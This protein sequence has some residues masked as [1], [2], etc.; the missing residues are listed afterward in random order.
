MKI[1][2]SKEDR[3]GFL[4]ALKE[5]YYERVE[6]A[7][8]E[9]IKK[10]PIFNLRDEG[11][12]KLIINREFVEKYNLE[13]WLENYKKEAMHSTGGI[14]GPQNVLYPWDSRFPL[15]QI[16]V[17]LATLG[18][19]LVLKDRI[20][21]REI[22]KLV[23]GEVRYN[24]KQYI[25]LISRIH[26]AQGIYTH[27]TSDNQVV[28]I[29]LTSFLIFMMDYDG[30]EFVTS[31]HAIS[32]KTATKDLDNQG[33]QFLPEMSMA[34]IDKIEGIIKVAKE[35]PEGYII[36][37]SPKTN[38]F[39]VQDVDGIEAYANYLRQGIASEENLS[40]IKNATS[41]GM[42]LMFETVGGCMYRTMVPLLKYF[43]IF[44]AFEWN[45]QLE[46]PFFH[47]VGKTKKANPKTGKEE[48]FDLSCDASLPEVQET[49]SY[50]YFLKE[51]PIGYVFLITDPDGDRL[52]MGQIEEASN[53]ENLRS[54][55]VYCIPI[56]EKRI[57]SFYH[58]TFSFLMVM[59]FYAK[60]LKNSGRWSDH[61]RFMIVTTPC[62]RAWN[63][64]GRAQGVK[65]LTTPVG[66]KEIATIIKKA[67]KKLFSEPDK[68]VIV[69]DIWTKGI[70]LGVDPR[71]IFTGEESGGMIIGPENI[72]QSRGGRKAI[73]MREKS[74]GEAS[75][76]ASALAAHLFLKKQTMADYLEEIF[77]ECRIVYRYYER[78]DITYYNESE[79][80]PVKLLAEKA[81]GE[82]KRDKIDLYYL[83]VVLALKEGLIAVGDAKEI[84]REAM[85]ELDFSSLEDVR[86]TGDA[87]YL[88]FENMFVQIRKSGTDAKLRGYSNGDNREKC[89]RYMDILVHYSGEITTSYDQKIPADFR[90][91]IYDKTKKI[92][93]DYL[94][95]GL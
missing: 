64:W 61:P 54:L 1:F 72:V 10:N 9:W 92:Y 65:I 43:G 35:S 2:K 48:F 76:I 52:T 88:A 95:T 8:P 40:L 38:S 14:R 59:D 42:R 3:E 58:P 23:A 81:Q 44:E 49:M 29:W 69:N 68:E 5:E 77:K 80:D 28:A 55:G 82:V 50:D 46:D 15:N 83:G 53:A 11:E 45:N 33:S 63:E 4:Q 94:Y 39:V 18:K 7:T 47:G 17:V 27:Q 36:T 30:G 85:P 86:F 20:K 26:S 91:A 78:V 41:N 67:E 62:S 70:N 73:V 79:P 32:G 87:T 89:L 51:K 12:I 66:F 56:D 71:I 25:E 90:K 93:G 75:I 74:A 22:N 21:D 24:T 84:F 60:Q 34:F 6:G 19:S 57:A 16:G 37:L 13:G 31:S